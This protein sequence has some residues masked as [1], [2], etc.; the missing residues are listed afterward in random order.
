[1]KIFTPAYRLDHVEH[2]V[3]RFMDKQEELEKIPGQAW[4]PERDIRAGTETCPYERL[5]GRLAVV[6]SI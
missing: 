6:G 4:R 3:N 1:M 2:R 5:L